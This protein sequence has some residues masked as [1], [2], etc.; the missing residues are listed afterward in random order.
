MTCLHSLQLK[1]SWWWSPVALVGCRNNSFRLRSTRF[2]MDDD[3]WMG[4]GFGFGGNLFFLHCAME[5]ITYLLPSLRNVLRERAITANECGW[6]E[7]LQIWKTSCNN[8][9]VSFTLSLRN[10]SVGPQRKTKVKLVPAHDDWC[11][12]MRCLLNP[13]IKYTEASWNG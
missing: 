9:Y 2:L 6:F 12:N 4:L 10:G 13:L 1:P 5:R 11:E 7:M 3:T 8:Y